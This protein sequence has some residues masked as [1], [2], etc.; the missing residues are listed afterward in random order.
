METT[1]IQEV[2]TITLED[3]RSLYDA[4]MAEA[5]SDDPYIVALNCEDTL[6]AY[7]FL[8]GH[9]ERL[10]EATGYDRSWYLEG[11]GIS[12][13]ILQAAQ[14]QTAAGLFS[15]EINTGKRLGEPD[16]IEGVM[17]SAL[18]EALEL[19][20]MSYEFDKHR[21]RVAKQYEDVGFLPAG[22]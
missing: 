17:G 20:K 21:R 14:E 4:Q 12:S 3:C 19:I 6:S 8:T 2:E 15:P 7:K 11:S 16:W 18:F 10:M 13:N 1:N 5:S 22:L 9:I